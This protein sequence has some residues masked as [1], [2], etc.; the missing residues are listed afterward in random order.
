MNLKDKKEIIARYKNRLKN[1]GVNV[2]ALASGSSEH[3][4]IRFKVMSEIGDLN[5]QKILD[6]GC[7]FADFYAYLKKK[8]VKVNYTGIDICAPFIDICRQRFPEASFEVGDIESLDLKGHFDYIVS[9]Q[10]FNNKLKFADNEKVIRFVITKSFDLC[11]KGVA[12]DMMTKYVDFEEDRLYYYKPE[13]IFRFCKTLTKRVALRH[14]YPLF[15]F[16]VFLYKDF[17]G[18]KV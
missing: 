4:D 17:K 13:K 14:D 9:S 1:H 5:N 10:T 12:I 3:Q 16:M 15:E 2:D 6:I 8:K 7:G 18:W 11:K